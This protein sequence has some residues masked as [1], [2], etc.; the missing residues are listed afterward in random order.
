MPK[1]HS[2]IHGVFSALW[3]AAAL[4]VASPIP[5]YTQVSAQYIGRLGFTDARHTR[6][7]GFQS[8]TVTA[9]SNGGYTVGTSQRF[10][11]S[12]NSDQ[13]AWMGGPLGGTKAIGFYDAAH[14]DDL[15]RHFS[16]VVKLSRSGRAI[17]LSARYDGGSRQTGRTA[18][19]ASWGGGTRRVGIYADDPQPLPGT[20]YAN[21]VF[22]LNEAGQSIGIASFSDGQYAWVA[23]VNGTTRAIGLMDAAH[24][25]PGQAPFSTPVALNASGTAVGVSEWS[26][27]RAAW[28]QPKRADVPARVIGI[29]DTEHTAQDGRVT[30]DVIALNEH[31]YAIGYA[32]R[33]EVGSADTY[34]HHDAWVST[35]AGE[36]RS[37]AYGAPKIITNSNLVG[38][39]EDF[40]FAPGNPWI[41][42][43]DSDTLRYFFARDGSGSGAYIAG[44]TEDG[45]AIGGIAPREFP[46][47]TV[48]LAPAG[49]APVGIGFYDVEH[50]GGGKGYYLSSIIAIAKNGLTVGTSRQMLSETQ[51]EGMTAWIAN[52]VTAA[53]YRIG[54]YD[55][56]HSGATRP[57]DVGPN[58]FASHV[59]VPTHVTRTR[60]AAGY[61]TRFH[62]DD[63]AEGQTA[64]VYNSA[65]GRYATF[66]LSVRASDGYSYSRVNALLENGIAV[67]TYTKFAE[68]GTD[69]GD[70]AFV[71]VT[72]RGA[73]DLGAVLDVDPESAGWDYLASGIVVNESGVIAGHGVPL[74]S[75][76]QGVYLVRL[77]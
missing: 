69:L 13:S 21:D 32:V 56:V 68:D 67:G 77:E 75:T 27:G 46:S 62:G 35:P 38:G 24:M 23:D 17:G 61:S 25:S 48:W 5:A 40:V 51:V 9:I 41:Y 6:S 19:L 20:G 39:D 28:L 59:S 42:D 72:G 22:D 65:A 76:S 70:R 50:N 66:D 30:N 53:T 43:I 31:G 44:L 74:S 11:S 26:G 8:S 37:I 14:T 49:A 52:P 57:A 60:F 7:D 45:V 63:T 3:P 73:Y 29:Y 58:S 33:E 4:A 54:L 18:W 55:A 34:Y 47:S 36:T 10:A 71:W 16:R 64:W 12:S 2:F 1:H 15:G